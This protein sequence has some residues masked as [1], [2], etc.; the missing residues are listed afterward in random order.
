M[1]QDWTAGIAYFFPRFTNRIE[2]TLCTQINYT[3]IAHGNNGCTKTN[4]HRQQE[5]MNEKGKIHK[6]RQILKKQNRPKKK[7]Q[8]K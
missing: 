8:K 7:T 3:S 4:M 6:K 5:L 1:I 2:I